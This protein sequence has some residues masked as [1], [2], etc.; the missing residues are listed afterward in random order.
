MKNGDSLLDLAG[1]VHKDYSE[2]LK[3]ARIWGSQ[4]HDGTPVKGDYV[5]VDGDIVEMHM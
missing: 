5:L 4:V 2:K 3:F 1:Q